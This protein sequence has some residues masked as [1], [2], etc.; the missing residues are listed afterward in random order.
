MK[1][2]REFTAL[3]FF[4]ACL[5]VLGLYATARGQQ[6]P[7]EKP[8]ELLVGKLIYVESMQDDLD[9]WIIDFLRRWGKY[10]ITANPEGVDLVIH[11][12][13]PDKELRLETRGGT[14]EP[15][16]SDRPHLPISKKHPELPAT[17][18]AVVNWV[19]SQT[20]WQADILNRKPKKDETDVPAGPQTKI[21]ARDMTSDQIA[22]KVVDK[23]KEYEQG[24]EKPG[25]GK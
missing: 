19:S 20:V 2:T 15:K 25:G 5:I 10:K 11:A 16:G 4:A 18:I 21:F 14:A 22:A 23:L 1:R 17:S 7:S 13:N 3:L 8:N 12:V 24:L 6:A 9:R